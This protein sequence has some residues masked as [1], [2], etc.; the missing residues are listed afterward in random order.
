[1]PP[2]SSSDAGALPR[3]SGRVLVVDDEPHVLAVALAMLDSQG[4]QAAGCASGEEALELLG[5]PTAAGERFQVL[6][7]DI[8]LPGGMSG[9][10]VLEIVQVRD[11]DLR[12]VACSGFFQEDARELCQAIG[13]VDILQKPYPIEN[14]CA[15]VRRCLTRDR[16]AS[17]AVSS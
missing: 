1:M 7:L 3:G 9:F 11:P 5:Q 17:P 6:V 15:V 2:N 16:S 12:V 13:F 10:D 8:T 4:I 14:L